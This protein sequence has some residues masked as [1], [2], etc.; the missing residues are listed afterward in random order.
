[1]NR[2]IIHA[3]ADP[4]ALTMDA[5][6]KFHRKLRAIEFYGEIVFKYEKGRM[7]IMKSTENIKPDQL[8]AM[9]AAEQQ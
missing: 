6:F 9:S 8:I 5:I 1:M 4:E 3:P 7:T 2:I